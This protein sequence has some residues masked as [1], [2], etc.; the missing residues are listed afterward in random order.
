MIKG[1]NIYF[2]HG[3]IAVGADAYCLTLSTIR[4]PQE[5]GSSLEGVEVEYLEKI[6]IHME[7]NDCIVLQ[8]LLSNVSD[9]NNI[10]KFKDYVFNFEEFNSKS[11]DVLNKHIKDILNL[12][13][14]CMAA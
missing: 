11:V 13:Y 10:V 14:M 2:G 3:T 5:V 8:K 9:Q 7:Y 12:Y 6:S 4:P 1:D